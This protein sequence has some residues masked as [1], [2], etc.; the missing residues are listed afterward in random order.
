MRVER[1]KEHIENYLKSEYRGDP[2]FDDVYLEHHALTDFDFEEI[3]TTFDFFDKTLSFP[4][5]INAM[6]GG[7]EEV[8]D[9][10]EDLARLTAEFNFAMATGSQKVALENEESEESFRAVREVAEQAFLLGNLSAR[11]DIEDVKKAIDLIK[12]D[13]MQLHLNTFQE[14]VMPEGD[15]H[16]KHSLENIKKIN[17]ELKIPLMVK[18]VGFGIGR[19]DALRLYE[20]GIRYIDIAGFGGTNFVEIE[21]NR[22]FDKDFSDLYSWGIPTAKCLLDIKDR[23]KDLKIIASGGIRNAVDIIKAF[24]LGADM[25]AISGE[26]LSYLLHGGYDAARN[27][28]QDLLDKTKILMISLNVSTIAELR[29]IDYKITGRLREITRK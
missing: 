18:E 16:F 21:D 26:V 10:N 6:T 2:L 28:L 15:R 23:P 29:N 7:G 17:D 20:A 11:E 1:K 8:T 13:G 19:K 9:I 3:K 25:V 14:M 22:Q 27:Y 12:A 4:L 5:L 24:V